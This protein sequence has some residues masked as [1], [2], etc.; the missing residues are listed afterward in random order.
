MDDDVKGVLGLPLHDRR[1]GS[2]K[3]ALNRGTRVIKVCPMR[4]D[5]REPKVW[6]ERQ[7][8]WSAVKAV[9]SSYM[10]QVPSH[11]PEIDRF[12]W[13]LIPSLQD[14]L[15]QLPRHRR[16][17]GVKGNRKNVVARKWGRWYLRKT[18]DDDGVGQPGVTDHGLVGQIKR[19]AARSAS[20]V[21]GSCKTVLLAVCDHKESFM[22]D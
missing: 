8:N 17:I 1:C 4:Q 9:L 15:V 12:M 11:D 13:S 14:S 21:I 3:N 5:H 7:I 6:V 16:D 18:F 10:V 22:R 19:A 20:H 2:H